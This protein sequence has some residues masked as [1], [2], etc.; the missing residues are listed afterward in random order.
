[1]KILSAGSLSSTSFY[2]EIPFTLSQGLIIVDV[3]INGQ[4]RKM[5]FD[6]GAPNVISASLAEELGLKIILEQKVGDSQ[7]QARKLPYT[8]IDEISFGET[9]FQNFGAIIVDYSP[10]PQLGCL[11]VDGL[12]GANLMRNAFWQIDYEAEVLRLSSTLE[13]FTFSTDTIGIPFTTSGQGTPRVNLKVG[14]LTFRNLIIDSGSNK[15]IELSKSMFRSLN[16]EADLTLIRG[17]GYGGTGVFG[18]VVDTSYK[19]ILPDFALSPKG[20]LETRD[21]YKPTIAGSSGKD[22]GAL[23]NDFFKYFTTTFDWQNKRVYLSKTEGKWKE[24]FSSIGT[25]FTIQEDQL[26][27]GFIFEGSAAQEA[28]LS[29]GQQVLRIEDYDF[30][31]NVLDAYC[32]YYMDYETRNEQESTEIEVVDGDS[33]RVVVLKREL[34]LDV[35]GMK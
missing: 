21:D 12:I 4:V 23:G 20:E 5:I 27:I 24:Q 32:G 28:G 6:T 26:R 2:E 8:T 13:S 10:I 33:S 7:D 29:R 1:M 34:M 14:D 3:T 17:Y 30:S 19:F 31:Q 25:T 35:G 18:Q 15:G 22:G 16:K 11:E 9:K